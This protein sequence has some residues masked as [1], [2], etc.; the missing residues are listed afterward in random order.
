VLFAAPT[1]DGNPGAVW[2]VNPWAGGLELVEDVHR[3]ATTE[4]LKVARLGND[5]WGS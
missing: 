3:W 1:S 5:I 4:D 2:R